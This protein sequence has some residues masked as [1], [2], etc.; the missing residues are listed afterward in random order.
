MANDIRLSQED[1]QVSADVAVGREPPAAASQGNSSTIIKGIATA[2]ILPLAKN[3][4]Q[5]QA[6]VD[7]SSNRGR[8]D[9][10]T[11]LPLLVGG[12]VEACDPRT[13]TW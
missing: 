8:D 4:V 13:G 3:R 5:A 12:S 7:A 1:A 9:S 11:P 6:V 2:T 10:D